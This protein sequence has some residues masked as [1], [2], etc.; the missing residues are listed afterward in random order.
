MNALSGMTKLNTL[1]HTSK[2]VGA[3]S[4]R[5]VE[6]PKSYN[7]N[8]S[9]SSQSKDPEKS[10]NKVLEKKSKPESK[11]QE[12]SSS[13]KEQKSD[14]VST[15]SQK[16]KRSYGSERKEATTYNR[17]SRQASSEESNPSNDSNIEEREK[18]AYADSSLSPIPVNEQFHPN[19]SSVK[20]GSTLEES[21]PDAL[22]SSLSEKIDSMG[23]KV[24]QIVDP[25]TRRAAIQNFMNKMNQEF[26]VEPLDLVKAFS[27]LSTE[28]L[29]EPAR[30]T[31]GHVV[32]QLNL[33]PADS[34]KA[35]QYFNEMMNKA[36]AGTLAEYLKASDRQ[37][38]LEVLSRRD[39]QKRETSESI[40]KM[41][42]SF[43][44]ATAATKAKP[45]TQ[46]A[47]SLAMAHQYNE[48]MNQ[49]PETEV[50]D[51]VIPQS[52]AKEATV[53][54]VQT[55]SS[56]AVGAG[57]TFDDLLGKLQ[58]AMNGLDNT[59]SNLKTTSVVGE[60]AN[61][62]SSEGLNL[63]AL[64]ANSQS[65]SEESLAD[66]EGE[67][68]DAMMNLG[69]MGKDLNVG[70]KGS[71]NFQ[72]KMNPEPSQM[73]EGENVNQILNKTQ[74]LIKKGGGE[75]KMRLTP[76]GMGEL[77]VKVAVENGKVSVDLV[78]ENNH[79]KKIYGFKSFSRTIAI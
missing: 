4:S 47:A 6:A 10:F 52:I 49:A 1:S 32:E 64:G 37:L 9:K 27:Q 45:Q 74:A 26:G 16:E 40:T 75:M 5:N 21:S 42:N 18:V 14:T 8:S 15:R 28:Q 69:Q 25:L 56:G 41:Q 63:A 29:G 58:L 50:A 68:S 72:I 51:A 30:E 43:F 24:D 23:M 46:S 17:R 33:D 13:E 73:E 3:L 12:A 34:L 7:D 36:E 60:S 54:D 67:G 2:D 62:S 48:V 77:N 76:E 59:S 53:T 44:G 39:A 11:K 66:G 79:V 71:E 55:Q 57:Q 31:V 19:L 22:I 35:K 20:V 38:S 61:A 65:S 70:K 78:T